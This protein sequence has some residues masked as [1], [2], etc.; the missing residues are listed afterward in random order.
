MDYN[1]RQEDIDLA[2]VS[3][4][5]KYLIKSIDEINEVLKH[6]FVSQEEF[7]PIKRIVY[8]LVATILIAFVGA[9]VAL[10][11]K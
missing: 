6:K 8:G 1:K 11:I 10:V 5:I 9:L 4:D 3:R 7:E 2:V